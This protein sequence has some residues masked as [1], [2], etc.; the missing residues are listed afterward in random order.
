M[1]NAY[2]CDKCGNFYEKQISR[3]KIDIL[4]RHPYGCQYIDLCP[5]C[6]ENLVKWLNL[7]KDEDGY[8]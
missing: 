4:V 3:R 5:A 2:K 7:D 6:Y 1:A 8:H